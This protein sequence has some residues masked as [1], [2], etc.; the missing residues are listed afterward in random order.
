V[1][2][3]ARLASLSG[4]N[5]LENQ[6]Q[7][8]L[9]EGG[10]KLPDDPF[11]GFRDP[12]SIKVTSG[13]VS[14]MTRDPEQEK[15]DRQRA[16]RGGFGQKNPGSVLTDQMAAEVAKSSGEKKL[17]IK[18]GVAPPRSK[19]SLT[20]EQMGV[21]VHPGTLA[22]L[23]IPTYVD[24]RTPEMKAADAARMSAPGSPDEPNAMM[25]SASVAEL[26]AAEKVFAA[27]VAGAPKAR[28]GTMGDRAN[29]ENQRHLAKLRLELSRRDP[30]VAASAKHA[31]DISAA[32]H[33]R[34]TA[35]GHVP[36]TVGHAR[37]TEAAM[38]GDFEDQHPRHPAGTS[39]GGEFRNK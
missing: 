3:D 36:G 32:A 13:S 34:A 8:G 11:Q 25:K 18:L 17:P 21:G 26:R 19:K 15:L 5:K 31:D 10:H 20:L 39:K 24:R 14:Q 23:G 27:R 38:R 2:A 12:E 29:I 1:E 16:P 22:S 28:A 37:A 33:D 7:K 4:R 9:R 35:L 30:A 6:I